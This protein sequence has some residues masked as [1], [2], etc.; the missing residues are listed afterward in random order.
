MI[1][2][3][4]RQMIITG[5]T[6]VHMMETLKGVFPSFYVI[7]FMIKKKGSGEIGFKNTII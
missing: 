4:L 5:E 1:I 7:E 6:S 3:K 2:E